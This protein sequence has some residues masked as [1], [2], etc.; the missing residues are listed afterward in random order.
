V[1]DAR[2]AGLAVAGVA[3]M[4]RAPVLAVVAAATATTALVRLVL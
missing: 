2:A 4:L 3:V 1:L